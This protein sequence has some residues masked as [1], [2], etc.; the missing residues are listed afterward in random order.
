MDNIITIFSFKNQ[1]VRILDI[2]NE[3]WFIAKD[4]CRIL[5]LTNP[6][7]ALEN[8]P[9]GWKTLKLLDSTSGKQETN[10]ISEAAVYRLIMRSNK[11]VAEKFQYWVCQDLLP[12][13]RKTGEYKVQEAFKKD[14]NEQELELYNKECEIERLTRLSLR[15]K[16]R[17]Y[18]KGNCIYILTHKQFGNHYKI[19]KAKNFDDRYLGY[20]TAV[21][22][23]HEILFHRNV[24][25]MDL[26]ETLI[27]RAFDSK[28]V[29][30]T[31]RE[32]FELED[33]DILINAVNKVC[34][35]VEDFI[36]TYSPKPEIP[37]AIP[38]PHETTKAKKNV[39]LLP[40]KP[41]NDCKITK[42]LEEFNYAR[43]HKDQ[44]ENVCKVCRKMRQEEI[45]EK[46]RAEIE[47]PSE[48][49]CNI[50]HTTL[51]LEDFYRDK[52]SPDGHMRRCKTCHKI[53]MNTP[54]TRIVIT[55][56]CCTACKVTK[57]VSEFYKQSRIPDGYKIYCKE[58]SRE[59]GRK[60]YSK[61]KEKYLQTKREKRENLW[62]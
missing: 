16:R 62:V 55:K 39:N 29:N 47:F 57:P 54:Q 7:M 10:I 43:E 8:I 27:I 20:V 6:S 58:C 25:E 14:L 41:C 45:L 37:I 61:N 46:Q 40:V 59:R 17:K 42:S 23:D 50:C 9:K 22:D 2:N 12:T 35:F 56:K 31:R 44:R 5:G 52:N 30:N 24:A 26:V 32:W 11:P 48:K 51:P 53:K 36:G 21:P 18:P 1:E 49:E 34:D 4:I 28:K 33:S 13:I 15:R 60:N 3:P 19:G 38:P